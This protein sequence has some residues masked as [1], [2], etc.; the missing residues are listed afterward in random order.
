MRR[1]RALTPRLGVRQGFTDWFL[2][3]SFQIRH[4]ATPGLLGEYWLHP[5]ALPYTPYAAAC[6]NCTHR[7]ENSWTFRTYITTTS[8]AG[9][10]VG[11]V[12][13][14]DPSYN[15]GMTLEAVW[16]AIANGRGVMVD[17]M[18][19]RSKSSAFT[20]RGS[21]ATLSNANPP[22]GGNMLGYSAAILLVYCL[23]APIG[24]SSDTE[25]N[26]TIMA[27]CHMQPINPIPGFLHAQSPT[28]QPT[29][30]GDG[31]KPDWMLLFPQPSSVSDKYGAND[32]MNDEGWCLS[33]TGDAWLAG[34]YYFLFKGAG[35]IV[36]TG[37]GA[38]VSGDQTS[39]QSGPNVYGL[40]RVGS[41]YTSPN[42]WNDWT[43]NN[44]N[45][46]KPI[47]FSIFCSPIS[48]SVCL[49]GFTNFE[50]AQ[51]QAAGN[52]GMVPAGAELC[53]SYH[54]W[55]T[56]AQFLPDTLRYTTN[57]DNTGP[58]PSS[59]GNYRY[60]MFYEVFQSPPPTGRPVYSNTYLITDGMWHGFANSTHAE[61]RLALLP[62]PAAAST[63]QYSV[64]PSMPAGFKTSAYN[65]PFGPQTIPPPTIATRGAQPLPSTSTRRVTWQQPSDCITNTSLTSC[66]SP[67]INNLT[68]TMTWSTLAPSSSTISPSSTKQLL[69]PPPMYNESSTKL[70][71][72][73]MSSPKCPT[74]S[75]P[76]K[77][78]GM[79]YPTTMSSGSRT[80]LEQ[81]SNSSP[82]WSTLGPEP[83]IH[84]TPLL[85]E[86]HQLGQPEP[87][88]PPLLEE[89]ETTWD[90]SGEDSVDESAPPTPPTALADDELAQR[91]QQTQQALDSLQ[92]E[93][94][95]RLHSH[96]MPDLST[97]SHL[98]QWAQ[99]LKRALKKHKHS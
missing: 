83:Q 3:A 59:A 37:T 24:L 13:L 70:T 55:P 71:P 65:Q 48:G 67:S 15:G 97:S 93:S 20:I 8:V 95:R 43:T 26:C 81:L 25:L 78:T 39:L 27:R 23:Q 10:R 79:T 56:W 82:I 34:G 40:P 32:S 19:N 91:I 61:P 99:M 6:A 63:R 16:G 9:A 73:L 88:A 87:T 49:V 11:L 33:H 30:G 17:S 35:G 72:T 42:Y 69:N 74:N 31:E 4:N 7:R 77:N 98:P 66:G 50:H 47:Y 80:N 68:P 75:M 85:H 76:C 62:P 52:T 5:I 86:L 60:A 89:S 44:D 54:N 2:L 1:S 46:R 51:A 53:I 41:V 29:P 38:V 28:F 21:T 22:Q 18:G 57:V 14:P 58:I 64:A 96:S 45:F 92:L 94:Q 84:Y 12:A 36:P 90:S